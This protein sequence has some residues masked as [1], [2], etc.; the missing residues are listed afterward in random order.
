MRL[1]FSLFVGIVG[2]MVCFGAHPVSGRTWTDK[3]GKMIEADLEDY[4][5]GLVILTLPNGRTIAVPWDRMSRADQRYITVVM[6]ARE[7]GNDL[8]PKVGL[9]AAFGLAPLILGS[10]KKRLGMGMLSLILCATLGGFFGALGSLPACLICLIIIG[11]M[12][13]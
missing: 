9:G 11:V 4:R 2:L 13:E 3:K 5:N 8:F 7:H 12:P 6:T 1:H 10:R